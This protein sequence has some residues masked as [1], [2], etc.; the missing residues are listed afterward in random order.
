[1]I[2]EVFLPR[3][4]ITRI[5]PCSWPSRVMPGLN[6]SR[7]MLWPSATTPFLAVGPDE[8]SALSRAIEMPSQTFTGFSNSRTWT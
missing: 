6:T 7:D 2:R 1:M 4:E 3:E 5:I 8:T